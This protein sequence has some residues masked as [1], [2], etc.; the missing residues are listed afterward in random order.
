MYI[1][2]LWFLAWRMIFAALC[3]LIIFILSNRKPV[4]IHPLYFYSLFII[5]FLN[6]YVTNICQLW[7]LQTL[8]AAKSCLLYNS[9]PF[10]I[11]ILSYFLLNGTF[12][13]KKVMAFFLGWTGL[14]ISLMSDEYYGFDFSLSAGELFALI[15]ATATAISAIILQNIM[16]ATSHTFFLTTGVSLFIGGFLSIIHSLYTSSLFTFSHIPPQIILASICVTL[17]TIICAGLYNYLLQFYSASFLSFTGFSAPI[18]A[19]LLDYLLFDAKVTWQFYIA[20]IF[21]ATGLYV[22]YQQDTY[23]Q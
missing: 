6:V 12:S 20:M 2:P 22:F 21:I 16:R 14:C 7:S 3:F 4:I 11:M 23:S 19:A 18:F 5:G 15:S 10:I 13:Y 1:N 17:A 9:N 8:S